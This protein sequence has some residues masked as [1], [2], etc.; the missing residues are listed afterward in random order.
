MLFQRFLDDRSGSVLPLLALAAIPVVGLIGASVDCSR[1]AAV[2]TAMQAAVDSTSLPLAKSAASQNAA[3]LQSAA[4]TYFNALF[5]GT[6][7]APPAV[8]VAFTTNGSSGGGSQVVVTATS[9]SRTAPA[10]SIIAI[11]AAAP[12]TAGPGRRPPTA[13]GTAASRIATRTT[14]R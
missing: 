7:A 2:Q 12:A 14:T 3:Q 13:P 1:A 4:Q 6:D 9:S 5:A 11:P 10:T 8:S